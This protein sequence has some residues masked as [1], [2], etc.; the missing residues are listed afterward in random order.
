MKSLSAFLAAL[1]LGS[2]VSLV[3]CETPGTC[4]EERPMFGSRC[5]R[6][7]HALQF[8]ADGSTVCACPRTGGAK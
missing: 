7:E 1:I 6:S 2:A 4:V 5:F 3:G 8:R